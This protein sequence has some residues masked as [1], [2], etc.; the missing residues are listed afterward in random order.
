MI[1]AQRVGFGLR[2]LFVTFAISYSEVISETRRI[3]IATHSLR[4]LAM[5]D[6]DLETPE[7]QYWPLTRGSAGCK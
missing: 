6:M 7:E 1:T 2:Q 5:Y 4:S 3:P